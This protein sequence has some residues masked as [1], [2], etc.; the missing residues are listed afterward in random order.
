MI[1]RWL[2]DV[3]KLEGVE[4][5][6]IATLYGQIIE[7]TG[8]EQSNAQLEA[9]SLYLLRINAAYELRGKKTMEIELYWDDRYLICKSSGNFILVTLCRSLQVL[10]LLRLN[11]NVTMA[12]L[13]DDKK[14]L[15]TIGPVIFN[16]EEVLNKTQL[17]SLELNLIT[18]L[19]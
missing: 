5:V 13:L 8:L 17:D 18:K 15:K 10:S 1:K 7:K 9:L 4:G 16:H 2:Q 11:L 3:S 6:F 12:K 14:F 19:K